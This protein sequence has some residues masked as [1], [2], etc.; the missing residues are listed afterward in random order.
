MSDAWRLNS[1][2]FEEGRRLKTERGHAQ[3]ANSIR[4]RGAGRT[5]SKA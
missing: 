1:R 4:P 2:D 5:P 3:S